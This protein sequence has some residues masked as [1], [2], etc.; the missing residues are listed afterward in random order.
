VFPACDAVAQGPVLES[1][2]LIG[3]W[4][5]TRKSNNCTEVY[6]FRPD[7]TVPVV[8]GDE[9]TEN[10]YTVTDAPDRNGFYRLAMKTIKDQGGRDCADDDTD[11]TGQENTSYVLFDPT[12][13]LHVNCVEPKLEKCFGPLK[14]AGE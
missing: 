1:H 2:P 11:S 8:S 6:D 5:W 10:V 4:Q 9:M 3:K 7:G 13:S 12:R 14:R